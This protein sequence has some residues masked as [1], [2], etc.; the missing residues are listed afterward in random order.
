M[1]FTFKSLA[2]YDPVRNAYLRAFKHRYWKQRL[3]N[4]RRFYAQFVRPDSLVFDVGA[5]VGEYA[6]AFLALGARVIAIEPT[7]SAIEELKLIRGPI[8]VVPCAAGA[9][10]GK[11]ELHIGDAD[12]LNTLSTDWLSIAESSDR[13]A[14]K[15]WD[16]TLTVDVVTLDSLI[17]RYG[18][19]EFVKID[20]EGFESSV[21]DGLSIMP[22]A[23]TFEFNAEWIEQAIM[24]VRKPLFANASFNFLYGEPEAF[25]LSQWVEGPELVEI[26]AG[27]Q[28]GNMYGDVIAISK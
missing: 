1:K 12:V 11:A 24:C 10:S 18:M 20:V 27:L 8:T 13:F 22:R 23:L 5:N 19:P 15:Q 7:P 16:R 4:V 3:Y 25:A 21:L 14:G 28:G 26:L 17:S 2:L 9:I 6:K